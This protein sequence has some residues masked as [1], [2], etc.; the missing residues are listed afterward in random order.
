MG[1][2]L[3]MT[4]WLI[5]YCCSQ[6]GLFVI[7]IEALSPT[8]IIPSFSDALIR[9]TGHSPDWISQFNRAYTLYRERARSLYSRA[10]TYWYPPRPQ[11]VAIVTRP[12]QVRPYCQPFHQNSWLLYEH[13]FDPAYSTIEFSVFLL[14]Q[15][16]RIGLMGEIVPALHANLPYFLTLSGRKRRDFRLGCART[17]RPDATAWRVLGEA[18]SWLKSLYHDRFRPPK[19][20][21]PGMRIHPENGL[22]VPPAETAKL[23]DL[24]NAWGESAQNVLTAYRGRFSSTSGQGINDL[25]QWL[26]VSRPR[27][28]I[29]GGRGEVL[30]DPD[31][32][33]AADK[34]RGALGSLTRAGNERIRLDLEVIDRHSSR[35][36]SSMRDP[37]AL[38]K[39]APHMTEGGL[40]YIHGD[41][42]LIMIAG[43]VPMAL[44]IGEAGEQ[45]A[46]LGRAVVGGLAAG[47]L[48]TFFVLPCMF[49]ILQRRVTTASGSLDPDDPESAFF[50]AN[51][52]TSNL[53]DPGVA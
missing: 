4:Q 46:P 13:D 14:F 23:E 21:M 53:N 28:L 29:T 42:R 19:L 1:A 49:T 33:E 8:G 30:W 11:H 25:A 26:S 22:I 47:T 3:V 2:Q 36:L 40:S 44:A 27:A 24:Q 10:P 32:P 18:Q 37:E 39:P 15:A 35:F 31:C 5:E 7:P 38:V 50:L 6:D 45:N 48:A 17:D 34:L 9:N 20:A 16:E 12:A 43:M 52:D 51:E 41:R